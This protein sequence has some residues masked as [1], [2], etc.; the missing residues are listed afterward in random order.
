MDEMK[1]HEEN[2]ALWHDAF[3]HWKKA[4]AC[5]LGICDDLR[6]LKAKMEKEGKTYKEIN[7]ALDE[8]NRERQ[9]AFEEAV[10]QIKHNLIEIH[11]IRRRDR[12]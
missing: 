8:I 11:N 2:Q 10:L 9:E 4:V 7:E 1:L 5:Q 12:K 6:E 3:E